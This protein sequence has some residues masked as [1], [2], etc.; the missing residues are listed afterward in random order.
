MAVRIAPPRP[1]R[2]EDGSTGLAT[3]YTGQTYRVLWDAPRRTEGGR[4][5]SHVNH[6][7]VTFVAP[8]VL[9]PPTFVSIGA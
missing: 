7:K 2:H 8:S 4:D 5:W 9:P 3:E 1:I 6:D